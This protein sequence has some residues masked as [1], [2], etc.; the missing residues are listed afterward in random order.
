MDRRS[1]QTFLQRRH[2]DCQK[3]KTHKKCSALLIIRE[4]QIKTTMRYLLIPA[5][6]PEWPS[7]KRLQTINAGEGVEKRVPYYTVGG[8]ANWCNYCGK[9]YEDSSEN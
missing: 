9:Q 4:M 6:Q 8:N 7:S 1:K 3:K 5:H 2:A